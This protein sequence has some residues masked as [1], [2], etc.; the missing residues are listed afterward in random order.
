MT[1]KPPATNPVEPTFR[2][3]EAVILLLGFFLAVI[4]AYV[5]PFSFD[6]ALS[7]NTFAT[8]SL[9]TIFTAYDANNHVLNTLGMKAMREVFGN[10]EFSLRIPA[11]IGRIVFL[12]GAALVVREAF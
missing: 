5:A 8:Q 3:L 6:E 7:Y 12:T 11:L 4:K 10:S 2:L 9:H 1:N